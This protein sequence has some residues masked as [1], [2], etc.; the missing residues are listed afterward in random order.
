MP[1]ASTPLRCHCRRHEITSLRCARCGVPI[2]PHC[3]VVYPAGMLCKQCAKPDRAARLQLQPQEL[4][5]TLVVG[6][7]VSY[8]AAWLLLLAEG[9]LSSVH[10]GFF[11]IFLAFFHGMLVGETVR[12][13]TRFK[14]GTQVEQLAWLASAL[15]LIGMALYLSGGHLEALL[16]LM[17]WLQ[18]ALSIVGA[19]NRV[20]AY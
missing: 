1:D 11:A 10:L 3:S 19:H 17:L 4:L 12:Q 13:V 9:V 5:L 20:R 8:V 15:G 2:C 6:T 18:I 7:V 14:R 16:D